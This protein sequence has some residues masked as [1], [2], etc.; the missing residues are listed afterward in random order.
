MRQDYTKDEAL[1]FI[2]ATRLTL[3]GKVGFKWLAEKLTLLYDY[4][5][6]VATENEE[7]KAY[8]DRSGSRDEYEA[9]RA[10]ELSAGAEDDPG[11]LNR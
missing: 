8:L 2:D 9:Y 1:A 11:Q 5:E 6:S 10:S 4:V 3:T 7:L